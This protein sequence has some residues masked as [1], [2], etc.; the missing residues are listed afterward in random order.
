MAAARRRHT[1]VRR[2]KGGVQ[3]RGG[4]EEG[5][6]E[7]ASGKTVA[8]LPMRGTPRWRPRHGGISTDPCLLVVP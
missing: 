5:A 8:V 6:D 1:H 7:G 2:G 3:V 4:E